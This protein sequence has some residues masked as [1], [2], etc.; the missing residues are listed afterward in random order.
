MLPSPGFSS[1]DLS[2]HRWVLNKVVMWMLQNIRTIIT[3]GH[4]TT[5]GP[6][7]IHMVN[8]S[9]KWPALWSSGQSFWLL[10]MRSRVQFLALPWRFFLEGEDSHGYHGLGSLVE[11][12]LR[13]LLVLHIHVSPSTSSGQRNCTSWA[14]KPQKSVTLQP[15]L[16]GDTTKPIG[17]C[18]GIG[19]GRVK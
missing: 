3:N 18:G 11:L 10:I 8:L 14:S 13:P 4:F 19:G 9:V 1:K 7:F 2:C 17:I 16:G 12:R 6:D 15:Q 5:L